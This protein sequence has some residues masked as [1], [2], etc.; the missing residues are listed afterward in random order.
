MHPGPGGSL[1]SHPISLII[2]HLLGLRVTVWPGGPDRA[3]KTRTG[4]HGQ[5]SSVSARA[6]G[7]GGEEQLSHPPL[8]PCPY[9]WLT[10]LTSF[11]KFLQV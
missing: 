6:T 4:A 10:L 9:F 7:T 5:C 2:E 3:P 1:H 11:K 8:T